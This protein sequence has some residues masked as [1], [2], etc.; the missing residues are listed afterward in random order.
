[1]SLFIETVHAATSS[2]SAPVTNLAVSA[3]PAQFVNNFYQLALLIGGLLA[4]AVIVWGGIKYVWSA[5]N[6]SGKSEGREWITGAF[7]GLLLL[8]SAYL[9]LNVI[10]PNLVNLSL[11]SLAPI[12]AVSSKPN[13]NTT[14]ISQSAAPQCKGKLQG[15]CHYVIDV[16]KSGCVGYG[17][18]FSYPSCTQEPPSHPECFQKFQC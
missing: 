16:S 1:M 10:N 8:L 3:N 11:P 17:T 9:I 13:V 18:D 6:P 4:F 7:W 2:I 14:I 5:G 15:W 12:T